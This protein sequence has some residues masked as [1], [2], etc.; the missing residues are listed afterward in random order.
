MG[1]AAKTTLQVFNDLKRRDPT[2]WAIDGSVG[3]VA[4]QT[5]LSYHGR[6]LIRLLGGLFRLAFLRRA[7]VCYMLCYAGYGMMYNLPQVAILRLRGTRL[8]IH[9]HS[10][11]YIRRRS[12]TMS[13]L[14]ALAGP[15]AVHVFGDAAMSGAFS[16]T[17]ARV[18]DTRQV[19]NAATMDV[20]P[21]SLPPAPTGGRSGLRVGYLSNL[22]AEKGFD[23]I[24]SVFE[25][26]AAR[27]SGM[28]FALAGPAM[29]E[30]DARLLARV[31]ASLG[32]RLR[33]FGAVQG[34]AKLE[35][36]KS[37]DVFLFPTRFRQEAQ[38]NVLYEAM[39]VGAVV[40][41]TRWAGIPAMLEGIPSFVVDD[42]AGLA[43]VIA[44]VVLGLESEGGEGARRERI[45][46]R[47]KQV[48]KQAEDAY[49]NLL[50]EILGESAGRKGE[51]RCL[52]R[53]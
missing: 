14:L 44:D 16:R 26:L 21:E 4:H 10:Y 41:A 29:T 22:C 27:S 23:V 17:Y 28:S 11:A 15:S 1:G 34:E 2:V 5:S 50:A 3:G 32:S 46:E 39:A 51:S 47:F 37:I 30:E 42:Q 9:H 36:F 13:L 52:P 49:G 35:F 12:W 38:P 24:V 40:V 48:R 7:D 31:R 18:L 19:S 8:Y 45:V 25:D 53:S 20:T 33:Y 6:R 43:G